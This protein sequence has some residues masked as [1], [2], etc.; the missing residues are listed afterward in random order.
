MTAVSPLAPSR[1][2]GLLPIDGVRLATAHCGIRYKGR[3]D[4]MVVLLDSGTAV[5][6][7]FTR[8]RT[9]GAPVDWCRKALDQG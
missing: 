5:A 9:Q 4:L 6:G 8:S 1:F 2:P 7:V 3:T